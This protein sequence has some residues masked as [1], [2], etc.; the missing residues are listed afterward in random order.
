MTDSAQS[1][2]K[3]IQ[4]KRTKGWKMPEGAVYVGRPT[5]WGNPYAI[6]GV[7]IVTGGATKHMNRLDAVQSFGRWV[8]AC[9]H[10]STIDIPRIKAELSGKDLACW[11]PLDQPCHADVLLEIANEKYSNPPTS[12]FRD[13]AQSA[14]RPQWIESLAEECEQAAKYANDPHVVINWRAIIAKHMAAPAEPTTQSVLEQIRRLVR[15][16]AG[17]EVS[18]FH[19][20]ET[21]ECK[22]LAEQTYDLAQHLESIAEGLEIASSEECTAL[23]AK[24]CA[25]LSK[26]VAAPAEPTKERNSMP[27]S[28]TI[29]EMEYNSLKA[30]AELIRHP[31]VLVRTLD[32]IAAAEPEYFSK[33]IADS[34]PKT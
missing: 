21:V 5:K 32:E 6:G 25:E 8:N 20:L 18:D 29:P 7:R 14:A 31:G 11:C 4:R 2:P 12:S 15:T 17:G 27:K 22:R 9:N 19:T 23:L 30:A 10:L 34:S 1:A 13:E 16:L 26:S 24:V 28:V 33:L 3:R